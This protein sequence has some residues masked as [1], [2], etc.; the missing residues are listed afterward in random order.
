MDPVTGL[1]AGGLNFAGGLIAQEKTDDRQAAA[2]AFNAQQAE[3]NRAFQERMSNTAYQRSMADMREAGLNPI[4]AYQK[5]G[6]SSP[7]GSAA[8]TTFTAAENLLGPAVSSAFSGMKMREEMANLGSQRE[9]IAADTANKLVQNP[10]T[11]AQTR[12]V[13]ADIDVKKQQAAMIG[14]QKVSIDTDT[15]KT[16]AEMQRLKAELPRQQVEER[17]YDPT[18]WLGTAGIWSRFLGNI[19]ENLGIKGGA[20]VPAGYGSGMKFFKMG[21]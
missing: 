11:Q 12:A 2:Q 6:A 16:L 13:E 4:L 1:V 10:L 15:M 14:S 19:M 7:T 3:L 8:S 5:G 17:F 9:N 20:S 18:T 21:M